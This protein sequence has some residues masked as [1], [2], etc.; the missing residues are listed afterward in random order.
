MVLDGNLGL[1]PREGA[2]REALARGGSWH[3]LARILIAIAV[4]MLFLISY[5]AQAALVVGQQQFNSSTCPSGGGSGVLPSPIIAVSTDL[6]QTSVSSVSGELAAGKW[7]NGTTGITCSVTA[8][9]PAGYSQTTSTFNL[10]TTT[11]PLG[12]SLST[13]RVFSG[14]ADGRAGQ[15]YAIYYAL[16]GSPSTF[17]LLGTVSAPLTGGS[18]LTSTYESTGQYMLNGVS[19]IRLVMIDNGLA[20]SGTVIREI[21]VIGV[22][23]TTTRYCTQIFPGAVATQRFNG[24]ITMGY[25]SVINNSG[26]SLTTGSIT[27]NSGSGW[28]NC[29]TGVCTAA[30]GG[31][32]PASVSVSP[33]TGADGAISLNSGSLSKAAGNYTSVFVASGGNTLNFTGGTY[34]FSSDWSIQ[35]NAVINLAPGTYWISGNV[36]FGNNV[37]IRISSVGTVRF[38]ING[39]LQFNGGV[40]T[41]SV[42]SRYLLFYANGNISSGNGNNLNGFF[43]SYG[44][45]IDFGYQSVIYGGAA[46]PSSITLQNEVVVNYE[47]ANAAAISLGGFCAY[48]PTLNNF[49]INVG[50]GTGSNCAPSSISITARDSSNAT[51]TNYTGTVSLSTSTANGDWAKTATAADAYGTLTAGASDSGAATYTFSASDAGTI[52]L[53]LSDKHAETLKITF[54]DTSAGISST[55]SNLSFSQNAFVIAATDALG[56]NLVAGRNHTYRVTMQRR[57]DT[58]T[59]CG[60]AS[61]YNVASVKMW[62]T[63]AASDPGGAAPS[64][65]NSASVAASIP[66][67]KPA[68]NNVTLNFSNGIADFSLVTTDVGRY[69]LNVADS[70]NSFAA[71]ELTGSSTTYPVRPFGFAVAVASNPAATSAAGSA[72]TTAGTNF[73]VTVTAKGWSAADDSNDDGIPDNHNDTDPSNNATLSNNTTLVKFGAETPAETITLSSVLNSPS[74]GTDPGLADGDATASDGRVLA[75]FTN[76]V[77]TTSKVYFGEVGIIEIAA[78]ITSNNYLGAGNSYTTQAKSQSGYVGRFKPANFAL[79]AATVTPFCSAVSEFTYLGQPFATAFTLS[80]QNALGATTAN[81]TGSFAKLAA[82]DYQFKAIDSAAAT[83]L[84]SRLTNTSVGLT[85][86]AGTASPSGNL[87]LARAVSPDG[88]F[89]ATKV[90]LLVTDSDSVTFASS[91]L[92]ADADNNGSNE[93]LLLRQTKFR[94]GRLQLADAFGPETAN[95]PVSFTTQ[96]WAGNHYTLNTDDSCTLVPRSAISYPGGAIASD[97]NRTVTL[98][99][100]TTQGQYATLTASNVGFSAGTAGHSFSAPSG[101]GTG[102]FVVQISVAAM[103]WLAYDWNQDGNFADTSLPNANIGFGSYR[104][105]DRVSYW[106]ERLE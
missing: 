71:S 26:T 46:A 88:P 24:V 5:A 72:F 98:T 23:T 40:T 101:G 62:L 52:V 11:N 86:G 49:L 20:G 41:P 76:G 8:Q 4:A 105:H 66:N 34:F 57:S 99:G 87:T 69:A 31:Y 15:S 106:R 59:S 81:Y 25:H 89:D 16:V 95:L 70:S 18:L 6:L 28:S 96:Y 74:G 32:K 83:V 94:Q 7:R 82:S 48:T 80:A 90:S 85:W 53:N 2:R 50:G 102:S 12:Y 35:D 56:P 44:G 47:A 39:Y 58:G 93:S 45:T 55:S 30:G 21:D 78:A 38:F 51:L 64:A 73:S 77:A 67:A 60:P 92:N 61:G 29:G 9:D 63:R 19:A 84:T 10:N 43:Y 75:S 37:Q 42:S 79:T 33:G 100:G 27:N 91:A 36:F 68:S 54:N 103:P 1:E 14:W 104:G 17:T 65:L 22:P 3:R 13:I 97:G